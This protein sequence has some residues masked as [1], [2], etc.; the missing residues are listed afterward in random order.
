[1]YMYIEAV[2][3]DRKSPSRPVYTRSFFGGEIVL[4]L[5]WKTAAGDIFE[6]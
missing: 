3:V 2:V 1:M 5:F 4:F 6:K